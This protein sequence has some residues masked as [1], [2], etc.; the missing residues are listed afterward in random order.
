MI[1][2]REGLNRTRGPSTCRMF[3]LGFHLASRLHTYSVAIT[4]GISKYPQTTGPVFIS[5][6]PPT[7]IYQLYHKVEKL[8]EG[9][10]I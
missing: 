10:R 9:D 4:D 6:E 3:H 1:Y 8:R 2:C 5:Y 7:E